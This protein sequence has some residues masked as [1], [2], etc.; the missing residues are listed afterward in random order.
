ME[1]RKDL[2]IWSRLPGYAIANIPRET[3]RVYSM[4][5]PPSYLVNV[6]QYD[7]YRGTL[8]FRPSLTQLWNIRKDLLTAERIFV[9]GW[10]RWTVLLMCL[11][12]K[13]LYSK[14]TICM[15]DT[16][17]RN[18]SS[19]R[20]LAGGM[21]LKSCFTDFWVS[22]N[23]SRLLLSRAKISENIYTGLY[24]ADSNIYKPVESKRDF[25]VFVGRIA[26]EKGVE[27]M[28]EL[29]SGTGVPIIMIGDG[30][31]KHQLEQKFTENI[32]WLG[33]KTPE[34]IA[35]ILNTAKY[36]VLLSD[37]EPWGVV[38]QEAVFC[39]TPIIFN[40]NIGAADDLLTHGK[41]GF[42]VELIDVDLVLNNSTYNEWKQLHDNCLKT[43]QELLSKEWIIP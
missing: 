17:Y 12:M 5:V 14:R 9:T 41:N 20:L 39:G 36:L 33:W 37:Y 23:R 11:L 28:L 43:R 26:K 16:P 34:E 4:G 27:K 40:S 18:Q 35:V 31:L 25:L 1:N 22:G 42:N 7:W 19:F 32:I 3:S 8:S 6:E 10:A 21:V 30:P 13:T 24:R 38:V 2:F 15:I 29:I